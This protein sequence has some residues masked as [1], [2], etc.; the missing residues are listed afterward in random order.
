[1]EKH[2]CCFIAFRDEH[3]KCPLNEFDAI[4]ALMNPQNTRDGGDVRNDRS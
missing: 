3:L 2:E 1:M 4:V